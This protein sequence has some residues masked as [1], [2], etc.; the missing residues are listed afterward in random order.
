MGVGRGR[1]HPNVYKRNLR[2]FFGNCTK[3][4]PTPVHCTNASQRHCFGDS[5]QPYSFSALSEIPFIQRKQSNSSKTS[6]KIQRK[7][8][9]MSIP[10]FFRFPP[11]E[12]Q[13]SIVLETVTTKQSHQVQ[14]QHQIFVFQSHNEERAFEGLLRVLQC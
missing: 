13:L 9:K 10:I 14:E 12:P 6:Q 4:R 7:N 5:Q 1:G 2:H 11:T 3:C 8:A